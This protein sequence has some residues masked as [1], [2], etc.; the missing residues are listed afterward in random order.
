MGAATIRGDVMKS[1]RLMI[2]LGACSVLLFTGNAFAAQGKPLAVAAAKK[3][4]ATGKADRKAH[5]HKR[6]PQHDPQLDYP[7]LG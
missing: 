2:A 7:Q 4:H 5:G 6:A 3:A 1:V